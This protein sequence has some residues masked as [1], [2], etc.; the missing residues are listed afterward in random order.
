[1]GGVDPAPRGQ[2]RA[3]RRRCGDASASGPGTLGS[4]DRPTHCG[5][6]DRSGV[7]DPGRSSSDRDSGEDAGGGRGDDNGNPCG[8]AQR[9]RAA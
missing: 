4:G 1:L 3:R 6:G 8:V 5:S 2:H 9:S 7:L